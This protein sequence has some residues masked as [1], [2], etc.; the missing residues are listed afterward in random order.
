[1]WVC[2]INVEHI[3]EFI[4]VARAWHTHSSTADNCLETAATDVLSNKNIKST[5][6]AINKHH[7]ILH[8]HIKL[9]IRVISFPLCCSRH[10]NVK[11]VYCLIVCDMLGNIQIY[12]I[13][14]AT[15]ICVYEGYFC[16]AN[17]QNTLERQI[18][19]QDSYE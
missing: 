13:T 19:R 3:F 2:R 18:Q 7:S 4:V 14:T 12:F 8:T 11:F 10:S 16:G 17:E 6:I 15:N 5:V 1:M 9:H